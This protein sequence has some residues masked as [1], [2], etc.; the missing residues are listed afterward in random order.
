[1]K[2]LKKITAKIREIKKS[3]LRSP[4]WDRLR[5]DYIEKYPTCAAC[6]GMESLQVHHRKPFHL[7]PELE[8]NEGNLI[9][10]CMGEHNCHLNIGHGDSF[11]CYN[12][13]VTTDSAHFRLASPIERKFLTEN[14]KKKRLS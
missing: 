14:A 11:K 1:M 4:Q 12:P 13:D 9:S 8:L 2:L 7:H 10:L 3:H 6:G 5:D